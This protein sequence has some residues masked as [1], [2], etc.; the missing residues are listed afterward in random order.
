MS[1]RL[2]FTVRK[3]KSRSRRA[4]LLFPVGR[5]H[6][7]CRKGPWVGSR[8]AKGAPVYLTAVLEYLVAEMVEQAGLVARLVG[9]ERILP[10]HIMLAVTRDTELDILCKGVIMQGGGM[11]KSEKIEFDEADMAGDLSRPTQ[12]SMRKEAKRQEKRKGTGKW[13]DKRKKQSVHKKKIYL[14][15]RNSG[16]F[17]DLTVS[18]PGCVA[19]LTGREKAGDL[20]RPAQISISDQTGGG[21]AED[22]NAPTQFS[23]GKKDQIQKRKETGKWNDKRKNQSVHKKTGRKH[24][25]FDDL[26]ESSPGS[27][28]DLTGR[29][30]A[31]DLGRPTQITFGIK[32][33]VQEKRVLGTE[34]IGDK[35]K[36]Q[37]VPKK[38]D[39]SGK[40]QPGM[41]VD[42]TESSPDTAIDP[43]G[44]EKL[45]AFEK[46]MFRIGEYFD[47]K[48]KKGR[49]EAS[50]VGHGQRKD[51]I[52]KTQQKIGSSN[53]KGVGKSYIRKEST[54]EKGVF[55]LDKKDEGKELLKSFRREKS[56]KLSRAL[57]N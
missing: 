41:S 12:L 47:K 20:S 42:L 38:V 44:A 53:K 5:I 55:G 54:K 46:E 36:I 16:L 32:E 11:D 34:A 37:S 26:T 6:R 56:E 51:S 29:E 7:I 18:S 2:G 4:G 19:E 10:R 30:N 21:K 45:N 33:K 39:L 22:F 52:Y 27:V 25:I 35:R 57:G 40:K 3:S 31:G 1:L 50:K 17:V 48:H 9:K 24:G 15:G 43:T 14:P 28:V 23:M 13:G 49:E 8:I